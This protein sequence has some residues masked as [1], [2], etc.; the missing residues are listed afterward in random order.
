MPRT[1]LSEAIIS[2]PSSFKSIQQL[3]TSIND[4]NSLRP[5]YLTSGINCTPTHNS[6]SHSRIDAVNTLVLT[7]LKVSTMYTFTI[8]AITILAAKAL[9]APTVGTICDAVDNYSDVASGQPWTKAP[10]IA[11]GYRCTSDDTDTC[12][13]GSSITFSQ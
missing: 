9:A 5:T 1:S 3:K 13:L 2:P 6:L 7:S 8:T 10:Q 12:S 4:P 11:G